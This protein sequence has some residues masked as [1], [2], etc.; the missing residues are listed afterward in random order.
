[1]GK[2]YRKI[3]IVLG[4]ESTGTRLVTKLMMQ[5][6]CYGE[7]A[8]IQS[9]DGDV[10]E[11]RWDKIK[12]TLKN[13]P[14]VWRRSFP[15]DGEY[16]NISREMVEPLKQGCGLSDRDFYFL[17]TVRDWFPASRSAAIRGHSSTPYT[18]LEKLREA[19]TQMFQFFSRF[20]AI[21]FYMVSYE[22]LVTYPHFAVP[23]MYRQAEI[24]VPINKMPMIV[25]DLDDKNYKHFRGFKKDAWEDECEE[26]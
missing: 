26:D 25:K 11:M 6:G 1:M 7:D 22:G 19:Y 21:T 24:F 5:A 20:P 13:Q 15:H 16:P 9:M 4:G 23:I 3:Y 12:A 8:H 2:I 10:K 14:I 17:V 18:A